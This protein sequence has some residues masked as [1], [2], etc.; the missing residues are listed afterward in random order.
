VFYALPTAGAYA[1]ATK[2]P[3]VESSELEAKTLG[4]PPV[5]V[6]TQDLHCS[7]VEAAGPGGG[8]GGCRCN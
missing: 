1:Y 2:P 4:V 8:G 6:G 3:F 7:E 5:S